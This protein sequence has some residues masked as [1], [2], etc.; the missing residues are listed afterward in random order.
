MN[1][2]NSFAIFSRHS[3]LMCF[4]LNKVS[5]C[6]D[7]VLHLNTFSLQSHLCSA[8]SMRPRSRAKQQMPRQVSRFKVE[9]Y[10][11]TDLLTTLVDR[12]TSWLSKARCQSL[13]RSGACAKH[14]ACSS[15]TS[16]CWPTLV[17]RDA[18][19]CYEML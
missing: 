8:I 4:V 3:V 6:F 16:T 5:I 19:R 15:S 14:N 10:T 12:L 9:S 7:H 17:M 1:F 11:T 2:G 13:D 18:M